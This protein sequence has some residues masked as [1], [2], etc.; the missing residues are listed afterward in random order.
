MAGDQLD[1]LL[2]Y[3]ELKPGVVIRKGHPACESKSP[4]ATCVRTQERTIC[5]KRVRV[6]SLGQCSLS[7]HSDTARTLREEALHHRYD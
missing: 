3:E 4:R 2:K 1:G 5:V 7:L 6:N